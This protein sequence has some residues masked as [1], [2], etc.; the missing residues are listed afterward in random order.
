MFNIQDLIDEA[1][2]DAEVR[3]L[4]WPN[5]VRC[6]EC[7]SNQVSKRGFHDHQPHRQGY[8]C[9][10]CTKVPDGP[11][12]VQSAD[13]SGIGAEP[14]GCATDDHAV[15]QWGGGEKKPILLEGQVECDE[16][17]LIA[18]H[19][20]HPEAVISQG[21]RGRKRRLKGKRGRGTLAEEKP[22]IFGMLQRGGKWSFRC[23]TRS[24]SND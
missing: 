9:Q 4:R 22:P 1:K 8:R 7:G 23:W 10:S 6:P 2:C 16:V 18:G 11:E 24:V 12:P 14:G 5:G 20:D 21:R 13:C 17:Y 19:K 3:K 15:A